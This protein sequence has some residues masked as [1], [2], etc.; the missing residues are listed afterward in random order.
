MYVFTTNVAGNAAE[1]ENLLPPVATPHDYAFTPADVRKVARAD[2]VVMNGVGGLDGWMEEIIENAGRKAL[3]VINASAGIKIIESG[4][5]LKVEVEGEEGHEEGEEHE[6]EGGNPHVWLDPT[7][8][9]RQVVNIRDGLIAADPENAAVY[10]RNAESYI[11]RLEKLDSEIMEAARS[12]KRKDF[13][14]FHD[15]FP[16]LA[17]RYGLNQ[18]GVIHE[19]PGKEPSPKHLAGLVK[20]IK[21]LKI[22]TIF[23]EPQFSPKVAETLAKDLGIEVTVLDPADTGELKADSYEKIMRRNLEVLKKAL[24]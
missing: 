2:V 20:L 8:A 9:I 7:N 19:F 21:E 4:A 23:Y 11:T 24:M 3:K 14:A 1:V 13:V 15:A 5:E 22:T 6:H 12:F 10:R 17:A 18:V 16:Y